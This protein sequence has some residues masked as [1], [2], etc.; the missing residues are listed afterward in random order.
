MKKGI[1]CTCPQEVPMVEHWVI[2]LF[3]TTVTLGE[4][5]IPRDNCPM[6]TVGV[7]EYPSIGPVFKPT[8]TR[9]QG[10]VEYWAFL[11]EEDWKA[12]VVR[13]AK[14]DASNY[15]ALKVNPLVVDVTVNMKL[16]TSQT[17]SPTC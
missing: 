2:L 11:S 10:A 8:V 6:K 17:G 12:E 16:M 13:L 9:T 15:Q 1:K 3:N 5:S 4:S 7:P 14:R